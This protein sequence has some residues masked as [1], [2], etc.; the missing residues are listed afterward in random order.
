[1]RPAYKQ[2]EAPRQVQ[3]VNPQVLAEVLAPEVNLAVYERKL[4]D[5]VKHFVS[6]LLARKQP[7]A[8]SI[9]IQWVEDAPSNELLNLACGYQHVRGYAAFLADI[10]W[11]LSAYACLLGAKRIGLRLRILEQ[12]MCPR[13]HV[14][15]LPLRLITSYAGVG[16]QWLREGVMARQHLGDAAAEPV[17]I[18]L[19]ERCAAGH[20]LLAKG[21]RW[22]GNEGRGLIHRSPPVPLGERRLLLTLDWLG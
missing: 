12:A 17:D 15:H 7:L 13:F 3:G 16:S 14:D 19:I 6:Q 20:V 18:G 4:S 5:E 11:L 8:E 21:E 9:S 1:M 22:A 2:R 10:N